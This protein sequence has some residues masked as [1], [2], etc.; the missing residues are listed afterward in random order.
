MPHSTP[1]IKL[2]S[3]IPYFSFCFMQNHSASSTPSAVP[4]TDMRSVA[5]SGATIADR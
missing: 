2:S 3:V 5:N 4:V 1:S